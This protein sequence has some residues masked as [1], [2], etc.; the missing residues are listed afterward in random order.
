MYLDRTPAFASAP[1]ASSAPVTD[2]CPSQHVSTNPVR[3]DLASGGAAA[4]CAEPNP[5]DAADAADGTDGIFESCAHR[6]DPPA[7]TAFPTERNRCPVPAGTS[8][9]RRQ[10]APQAASQ[11]LAPK[12]KG[13]QAHDYLCAKAPAS[14]R[15]LSSASS[16]C[17]VAPPL[18][19]HAARLFD[20]STL[21]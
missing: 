7:G 18:W 15:M 1:S 5:S 3:S 14:D 17:P 9:R 21:R 10:C 12:Y 16:E 4:A 8:A 2:S 6:D 13:D 20:T 11:F 19:S